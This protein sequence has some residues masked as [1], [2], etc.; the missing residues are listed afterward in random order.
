MH[1]RVGARGS[2]RLTMSKS[3]L[4]KVVTFEV[5][6]MLRYLF[7]SFMLVSFFEGRVPC[8]RCACVQH[9]SGRSD[10]GQPGSMNPSRSSDPAVLNYS[11][12]SNGSSGLNYSTGSN[13]SAAFN[14]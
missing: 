12:S 5:P 2:L 14:D 4:A 13:D 6:F 9:K 11:T 10:C 3:S 1:S 8:C 7:S